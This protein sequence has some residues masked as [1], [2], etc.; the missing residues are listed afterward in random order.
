MA[1]IAERPV[2]VRRPGVDPDRLRV[3][4][5]ED[6]LLVMDR[7]SGRW[8][9][10]DPALQ[11]LLSLLGLALSR[12]PEALREPTR[13]LQ[14][15]LLSRSVGVP[16]SEA[17]FDA[18]NTVIIKLTNACNL[19]CAYCYDHERSEKARR[20][21]RDIALDAIGQALDLCPGHLWVI[22]H[23]GEPM[24]VWPLIEDLVLASQALARA[25]GKSIDFS[26][27]TNLSRLNDR[28]VT[29]SLEHG[30]DWGVSIDGPAELHDRF[31]VRHD[32]RGSYDLFLDALQRY[33]HFVRRCGVMST[34][35]RVNESQLLELARHFRDL[36][37]PS[38]DW[39]LF[40][41]IGR[42]RDDAARFE[43][44]GERVRRSWLQLLAAVEAGEF[45]GFRVQ[46][47]T[48]YL[49]NLLLGPG[50]NMC[51][52]PQ[53]GAARDLLSVSADGVLEACDCI[54]P[55]GP[56]S[57][58]GRVGQTTLTQARDS[59]PAHAIRG[60]D[61]QAGACGD[62]LW[63][64][65]CGGTCLAHAPSLSE[66]WAASCLMSQTAFDALTASLVRGDELLRYLNTLDTATATA[67][68][69]RPAL[70]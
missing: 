3:L 38:W 10:I 6:C 52:R 23:G 5:R 12:V 70:S 67:A 19:A 41:P 60:R 9:T 22:L 35:T 29:F 58:L 65:L 21:E 61:L 20:I 54:D 57:G 49:D 69:P 62:C 24:L 47:V 32:G 33:P 63:Y 59:A 16:G 28:V 34:I 25:R 7:L 14:Q 53:C 30:I 1:V 36:G 66:V 17:R 45:D 55:L 27:Q 31:R 18:L 2:T 50:R 46:P 68:G 26:G 56:L 4:P 39:T 48:K 11:P 13:Q 37:M 8:V 51:M 64:G 42:G 44:D 15:L 40:Q 43:P